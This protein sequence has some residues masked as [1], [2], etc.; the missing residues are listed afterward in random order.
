MKDS[1]LLLQQIDVLQHCIRHLRNENSRLKVRCGEV[2]CPTA[3]PWVPAVLSRSQWVP[4]HWTPRLGHAVCWEVKQEKREGWGKLDATAQRRAE[5]PEGLAAASTAGGDVLPPTPHSSSVLHAV[6]FLRKRK[7]NGKACQT[8]LYREGLCEDLSRGTA[9]PVPVPAAGG[10]GSALGARQ[11]EGRA[12][13]QCCG[14]AQ[15]HSPSSSGRLWAGGLCWL[16]AC[17]WVVVL[18][19][20]MSQEAREVC[21]GCGPRGTSWR[22]GT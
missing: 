20:V 4:A 18:D 22:K 10:L 7:R 16:G 8:L 14:T 6:G 5:Q 15:G 17:L 1:P 19:K 9:V 2:P 13:L 11:P 21:V 3:G 12:V